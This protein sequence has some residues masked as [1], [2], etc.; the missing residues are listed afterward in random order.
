MPTD[1][2]MLYRL[3]VAVLRQFKYPLVYLLRRRNFGTLC[4]IDSE[5]PR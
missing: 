2:Q 5:L 4:A 3:S 1:M